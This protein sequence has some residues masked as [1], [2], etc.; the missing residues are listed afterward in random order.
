[1]SQRSTRWASPAIQGA[2]CLA[3]AL[4][5]F[6]ES[7]QAVPPEPAFVVAER[8]ELE[9]AAA[10]LRAGEP[11][12]LNGATPAELEL[13]PGI[14]PRLAARIVAGRPYA[15][16]DELLAIRGVGVRILQQ[17]RPLLTLDEAE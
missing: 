1:M 11:L 2:L 8:L 6:R 17:I 15:R 4:A 16:V 12:S 14:G 9:H 7:R 10:R 13:L 3:L 5:V